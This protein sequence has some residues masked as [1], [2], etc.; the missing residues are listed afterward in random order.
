MR[1][2][3]ESRMSTF[4]VA[5][6]KLLRLRRARLMNLIGSVELFPGQIPILAIIDGNNGCTQKEIG[7]K[8]KFKPASITDSL[9][10]MEKAGLINREQDDKDLRIT[11]VY[12]TDVGKEQLEKS[13]EISHSFDAICFA[14]FSADEKETFISLMKKMNNN[15]KI[16]GDD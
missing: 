14:G 3:L 15:L 1:N 2:C 16:E 6:H 7:E 8:M 11:R 13:V 12:I 10:R 5:F 4:E 9:K